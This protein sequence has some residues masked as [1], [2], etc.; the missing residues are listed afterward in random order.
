MHSRY[1][2]SPR[3]GMIN[4]SSMQ[5]LGTSKYL[6]IRMKSDILPSRVRHRPDITCLEGVYY[7]ARMARLLD[8]QP[9]S[10]SY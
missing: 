9:V 5:P 4:K 7:L 10:L 6:N 8:C 1:Q 2:S 3:F